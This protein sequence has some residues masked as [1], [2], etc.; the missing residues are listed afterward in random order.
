MIRSV[1]T[2]ND[3]GREGVWLLAQQANGIPDAKSRSDFLEGRTALMLFAEDSLNE[4]LCVT[5]AVRQ[6]GG[7]V[8]FV[9]KGDWV[10]TMASFPVQMTVL[11]RYYVDCTYIYGVDLDAQ[12][13]REYITD[14]LCINLG[15]QNAEPA[16]V[17]ADLACLLR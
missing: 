10:A 14:T 16:N 12:E 2:L 4:R 8:V 13:C 15:S 5:A 11:G 6:M 9:P 7:Q 1:F 3:I 17:L